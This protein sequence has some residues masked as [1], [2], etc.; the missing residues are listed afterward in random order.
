MD[1][2]GSTE[3]HM[4]TEILD[5]MNIPGFHRLHT[6]NQQKNEKSNKA[7]KG[8]AVFVKE[9]IKD[10]FKLEK[11]NN[12][13]VIWVKMKKEISGENKDIFIGTC[14]LNP[15][16]AKG[17]DKKI[18]RL[19]EDIITLQ[20]R[21]EVIIIGDLNARTGI[22]ENTITPDKLDEKFDLCFSNPRPKRNSHDIEKIKEVLI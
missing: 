20:E 3:T 6:K 8:I 11:M 21:G 5:K 17:T 22:M 4:Y 10:M 18:S 1:F 15:S 16:Q 12:D 2:V 19:A 14:Y 13:D 9:N 7:P